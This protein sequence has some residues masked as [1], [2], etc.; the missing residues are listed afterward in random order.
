M[1]DGIFP[2]LL[3]G[4]RFITVYFRT[5]FSIFVSDTFFFTIQPVIKMR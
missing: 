4:R 3:D 1:P 2:I 5:L